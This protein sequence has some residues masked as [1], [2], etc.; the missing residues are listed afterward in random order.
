MSASQVIWA[1][2]KILIMVAFVLNLAGILTWADRRQSAMIQHRIGPNR[3]V[4]KI[5]GKEFRLLGLLHTAADG[6]KFFTKE[7]FMPP[8]AD[9]LLFMLAPII[10][11][12]AVFALLAAIPF[13]D[14]VCGHQFWVHFPNIFT[15][16]AVQ[17]WG[18]CPSDTRNGYYPIELSIA[19]LS[20]GMLYIFA[21]S[22]QGI[23]G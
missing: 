11:M 20:V 15:G 4:V 14:T 5:F 7:D 6:I 16:P 22:G 18:S 3:A 8:R 17:R 2:V 23:I 21:I 12:A 9:P 1:V 13:G 19:P 10:A